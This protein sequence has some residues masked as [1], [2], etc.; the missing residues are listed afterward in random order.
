M[1]YAHSVILILIILLPNWLYATHIRAGEI[2]IERTSDVSLNFVI[3]LVVI[4]DTDGV[5]FQ[6]GELDLGDG[7]E[8]IKITSLEPWD[9]DTLPDK[10]EQYLF[11]KEHRYPG[12]NKYLITY[13]ESFRNEGIVNMANSV[14][15]NFSV[16][17]EFEVDG[18][19]GK[20]S[21]PI[22]QV[23][24]IDRGV[25][26]APFIHI[27]G[28]YDADDD[29]LSYEIVV[30]RQSSSFPVPGYRYPNNEFFY[31]DHQR[32]NSLG[33]GTPTF[34]IDP[35][36]GVLT[37]D[38]PGDK[39]G[40]STIPAEYNMAFKIREWRQIGGIWRNIGYVIRDMQVS[41]FTDENNPPQLEVPEEICVEAGQTVTAKITAQDP[42]M[43]SIMI[44]I[45]GVPTDQI[46]VDNPA[47]VKPEGFKASPTEVTFEWKTTCRDIRKRPYEIVVKATDNGRIPLTDSKVFKIRVVAPKPEIENA[48]AFSRDSI[49]L[50]WV[51]YS[52]G[53]PDFIEV[54]RRPGS[55]DLEPEDC[56][57][58][59]PPRAG[60]QK[61]ASVSLTDLDW[62]SSLYSQ[63]LRDSAE[64]LKPMIQIYDSVSKAV[65]S[66][67]D[68]FDSIDL[69]LDS[70]ATL[71][72]ALSVNLLSRK[73]QID[74]L[75][76]TKPLL[77]TTRDSL[78][79][80][81]SDTATLTDARV[82]LDS[83][84]TKG[85]PANQVTIDSLQSFVDSL[86]NRIMDLDIR[87]KRLNDS[88]L[89]INNLVIVVDSLTNEQNTIKVRIDSLKPILDSLEG[90][91]TEGQ[92]FKD[93]LSYLVPLKSFVRSLDSRINSLTGFVDKNNG[94]KFGPGKH[95]Y[96]LTARFDSK[97]GAVS[98]VSEERCATFGVE[99]PLITNSD[100][101]TTDTTLGEVLVQWVPPF[102]IDTVEYPPPY[103]YKVFR[104]QGFSRDNIIMESSF[105]SDTFFIDQGTPNNPLNTLNLPYN[106]QVIMY[107]ADN[108]RVVDTSESASTVRLELIPEPASIRLIWQDSTPWSI[109]T[110]KYP[111]HLIYRTQVSETNPD[112]FV[113]LD[114]LNV[115]ENGLTYSDDSTVNNP[116]NRNTEYCYFVRTSGAYDG[117]RE[118]PNELINHSQRICGYLKDDTN[119]CPVQ[120]TILNP[121]CDVSFS[122]FPCS[123][124]QFGNQLRLETMEKEGCDDL[125]S[126]KVYYSLNCNGFQNDTIIRPFLAQ[127][128]FEH[129]LS[130]T[131]RGCYYATTIDR[132]GNE[133]PPSNQVVVDNCYQIAFPNVFTPNG[134]G[135]NDVFRPYRSTDTL[136]ITSFS[137]SRCPRFIDRVAL[138][139]FDRTGKELFFQE[140][141]LRDIEWDGQSSGGREM[142]AG[143]YF[144]AANVIYDRLGD[145]KTKLYKGWLHLFRGKNQFNE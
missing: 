47:I 49:E 96:R 36:S 138:K 73:T 108:E 145:E 111:F 51:N 141:D 120:L 71:D 127:D 137:D 131:R 89:V 39:F 126:H 56:E 19:I 48:S 25:S 55:F 64:V 75:L 34:S 106:Y 85:D 144:Y 33:T 104:K 103:S 50:S 142:P 93:S 5:P 86:G 20:N 21:S 57:T 77:E 78:T 17:A 121:D 63:T 69:S 107:T 10:T 119:D 4:R 135:N 9:I 43:D 143:T 22:L 116:L 132:S 30:P 87:I 90:P 38:S 15:T 35:I 92:K 59:M 46:F 40:S 45:F 65:S 14:G 54:W 1:K 29:S 84:T 88:V 74:S 3:T 76:P 13:T 99:I 98:Y 28:A 130:E 117:I 124:T 12:P 37:W 122:Q 41:I 8:I 114:S 53:P 32:G 24:P 23:P 95:C 18:L 11:R 128:E 44:E 97:G 133:G 60:Y 79:L 80:H 136:S 105:T 52:C 82:L 110:Q 58:G 102:D 100:I 94:D 67:V 61:I 16:Q 101:I 7:S 62:E 123:E 6:G 118:F 91:V 83:L 125:K 113:L 139:I 68:R 81:L 140:G 134:D 129:R 27:P 66:L 112:D 115:T 31:S 42:E 72:S 2:R 109:Q 26:G 70:L